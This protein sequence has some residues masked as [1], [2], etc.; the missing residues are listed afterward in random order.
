MESW[1]IKPI[2]QS[3]YDTVVQRLRR[4][5]DYT[6]NPRKMETF[7]GHKDNDYPSEIRQKG[8]NLRRFASVPYH[9][10]VNRT[11]GASMDKSVWAVKPDGT[12]MTFSLSNERTGHPTT[13]FKT[14]W[15]SKG[16]RRK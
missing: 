5:G 8:T 3:Q 6:Y 2:D 15:S 1:Q 4:N 13:Q 14:V 9:T 7:L 10:M 11:A 16:M 12:V